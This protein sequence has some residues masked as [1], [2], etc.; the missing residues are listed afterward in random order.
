MKTGW[1]KPVTVLCWMFQDN[2]NYIL[3]DGAGGHQRGKFE[4]AFAQIGGF[5]FGGEDTLLYLT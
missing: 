1:C 2:D 3:S 4:R 5:V